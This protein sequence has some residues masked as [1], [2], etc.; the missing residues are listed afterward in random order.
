MTE[1]K[2]HLIALDLIAI[3]AAVAQGGGVQEFASLT[4]KGQQRLLEILAVRGTAQVSRADEGA[5][6][7]G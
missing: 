5:K 1:D 4:E 3:Q 7:D 6:A 2:I